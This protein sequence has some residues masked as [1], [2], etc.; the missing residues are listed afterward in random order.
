MRSNRVKQLWKE[1]KAAVGSWLNLGSPSAAELLAHIGFDWIVVDSEHSPV[2]M[3]TIQQMFVALSTTETVPMIRVAWNDP[4]LI[5]RALDAGAYGV[6]VPMVNSREEAIQAV[7]ACRYPPAGTRSMGFGRADL[8]AGKDYKKNANDEIAV[9]IQIEHIDAVENIDEIL[10]V[11]GIDAYFIGPGDLAASMGVPVVLGENKDLRH[12]EA[13][14]KIIA[15]GKKYN[16]PSGIHVA[17]AEEVNKRIEEG[18]QFIALGTDTFFLTM[19]ART[20]LGEVTEDR[21]IS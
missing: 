16:V 1:N 3:E 6:V 18:F 12:Q 2:D 21:S 14:K 13:I 11:E 19:A 15:A 20:A 5:K 17:R 4:I 10:S 8:Y 9:I 7:K